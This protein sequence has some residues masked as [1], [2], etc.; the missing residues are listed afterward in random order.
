MYLNTDHFARR[1]KILESSL[2]LL[3]KA[4]PESIDYEIFRNAVV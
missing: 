1:I 3:N 4:E 2:T